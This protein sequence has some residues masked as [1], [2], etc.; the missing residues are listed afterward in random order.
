LAASISPFSFCAGINSLF[1]QCSLLF[2]F[3]TIFIL[4]ILGL[5]FVVAV[6]GAV[7]RL[8]G[9][10]NGDLSAWEVG[11]VTN[12]GYSTYTLFFPLSKIGSFFGC[13]YFPSSF[14]VGTDSI[15]EQCL[16]FFPS[17]PFLSD[18]SLLLWCSV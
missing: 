6:C 14:F 3:Q 8:A 1:E 2:I 11:K 16:L 15:F 12:M 7:F 18:F 13:F 10:F 17:N 5:F 9:A 4:D